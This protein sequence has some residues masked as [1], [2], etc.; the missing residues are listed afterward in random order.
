MNGAPEGSQ[1]GSKRLPSGSKVVTRTGVHYLGCFIGWLMY[2]TV[3]WVGL[4]SP[5]AGLD[6]DPV[7]NRRAR[8]PDKLISKFCMWT[9]PAAGLNIF[10]YAHVRNRPSRPYFTCSILGFLFD[11]F[12]QTVLALRGSGGIKGW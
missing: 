11:V 10:G 6:F 9:F 2:L 8:R 5:T 4:G 3:C 1:K 7:E 12:P